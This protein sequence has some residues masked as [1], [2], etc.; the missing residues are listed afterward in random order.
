MF[1]HQVQ[2][3]PA[4]FGQQLPAKWH[5]IQI[6]AGQFHP[7]ALG[8]GFQK[9][10]V[11]GSVV[12]DENGVFPAELEK[13]LQGFCFQR[14]VS[15]HAFL[16]AGEV[17][18]FFRQGSLGVDVG[19]KLLQNLPIFHQHRPDFN[20]PVALAVQ[21]GGLQIEHHIPPLNGTVGFPHGNGAVAS[22]PF[23]NVVVIE[24]VGLHPV[25]H[26]KVRVFLAD[27]VQSIHGFRES[28]HHPMIGDG[29]RTVT[30]IVSPADEL[31]SGS[32]AVHG[33]DIGVHMQL[34]SLFR[35]LIHGNFPSKDSDVGRADV[36]LPV[37]LIVPRFSLY[38]HADTGL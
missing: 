34:H 24:K 6:G 23:H 10:H 22:P 37:I 14:S 17:G 21:A 31:G 19:V 3:Y 12:G 15:E 7:L 30:P 26:L 36:D 1:C 5:G 32:H 33:R 18:D 4:K 8:G 16:N 35:F 25:D 38:Q 20:N 13:F 28:L 11:K 9:A 27:I 29:H 2:L